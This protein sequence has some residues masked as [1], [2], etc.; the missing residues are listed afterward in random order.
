[1][2]LARWLAGIFAWLAEILLT[3]LKISLANENQVTFKKRR[4]G[5]LAMSVSSLLLFRNKKIKIFAICFGKLACRWH[6]LL[7]HVFYGLFINRMWE[8]C[9]TK[10][11]KQSK[12]DL[13]TDEIA[14]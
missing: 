5:F 1:M 4:D 9:E 3:A 12:V 13:I 8:I 14:Y 6:N 2:R 11:R 7:S 10:G